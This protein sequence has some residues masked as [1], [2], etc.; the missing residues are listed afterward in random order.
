MSGIT[1]YCIDTET[2]GI[3]SGF[4]EMT[5]IGVIKASNY[6]QLW[7]KIK[8]DY[9]E[10]SSWDALKITGK[11]MADL[12]IGETKE[13]IVNLTNKF[14][15]EDGL[16]PA[17]RC[18]IAHNAAFDR[19][20]LHALW[21]SVGKEFPASLWLDTIALTSEFIKKS[22]PKTL[23]ITKTATGKISKTLHAACD[24]VGI[25]KI[26]EAHN[27]RVDSRNTILLWKALVETHKIDYIPHIKTFVHSIATQQSVD[28]LLAE[29]E[30]E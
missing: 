6:V 28:E 20:F 3:K 24:L 2:N 17:H 11:T 12:A 15:N 16:T 8:C 30:N 19:R 9:P 21:E 29:L 22:D 18:I 27:A 1:Y 5:E 13:D 10:R 23:N 26:A 14:L 7:K 25:K 4:H